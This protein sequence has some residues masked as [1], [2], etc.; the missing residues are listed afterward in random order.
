MG[1]FLS[2]CHS[3]AACRLWDRGKGHRTWGY[4][5]YW[6]GTGEV[7]QGTAGKI[8]DPAGKIIDLQPY[9]LPRAVR[10]SGKGYN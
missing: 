6:R 10:N 3:P 7:Q 9:F 8:I 5:D 4:W 1:L 2:V